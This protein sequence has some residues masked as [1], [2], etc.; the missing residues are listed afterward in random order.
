VRHTATLCSKIVVR[1][2]LE[3]DRWGL[4]YSVLMSAVNGRPSADPEGGMVCSMGATADATWFR[5]VETVNQVPK[6]TRE[7]ELTLW[8]EWTRSQD[9]RVRDQLI[10]ANLRYVVAIAYKYRSYRLPLIELAAEG[11][12][13]ILHAVRKFD[14]Q[15][16]TRFV[17]YAAHWIRAYMLNYIIRSWSLVCG[18]SGPLHSRRFF[19]LRRE[20]VRV[21]ALVGEGEHADALLA[22]RVGV[23]PDRIADFNQRLALRDESL[24][25]SVFEDGPTSVVETLASPVRNQEQDYQLRQAERRATELVHAALS[26]LDQRERLIAEACWMCDDEEQLSLAQIGRNLGVSRER[27]RQLELRAKRKL[28]QRI[29]EIRENQKQLASVGDSAA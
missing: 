21:Y 18:G 11:N 25:R 24:D 8:R 6:L 17:T 1:G 9:P 3:L 4:A 28:R 19:K 16:G 27:A 13:A 15:R 29:L 23:S 20:Q 7:E 22:E 12:L 5:Y 26:S 2:P 14:P 10:R